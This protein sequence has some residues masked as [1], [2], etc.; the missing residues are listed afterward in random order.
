[1]S[2]PAP[3]A[4]ARPAPPR[5]IVLVAG[6]SGS[7]KGLMTQRSGLPLV[8]LDEFYRDLDDPGLPRRFGIVDWD[9]PASWDAG[10]ALAALTHLA[11]EGAPRSPS[12]RSPRRAAPARGSSRPAM[13]A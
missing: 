12:T 2:A 11:H 4:P 3:P 6:P 9:D 1:M 13:R 7:G 8:Q 10:A 5:Q